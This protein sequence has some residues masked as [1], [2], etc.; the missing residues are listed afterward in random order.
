MRRLPIIFFLVPLLFAFSLSAD[1]RN[2]LLEKTQPKHIFIHNRIVAQVQGKPI[3]IIDLMKKM[4]MIFYQRYPQYASSV[5]ARYQFYCV[6][7]KTV[8]KELIEKEL[9][10]ADAAEIKV[11]ITNGDVRQE[12]ERLF[13][14]HIVANLDK[15]GLSYEEASQIVKE[16]LLLK[17]MMGMRVHGKAARSVTPK[18]VR[19]LYE[20]YAQEHRSPDSWSY[21]VISV[22]GKDPQLCSQTATALHQQLSNGILSLEELEK[23]TDNNLSGCSI[24]KEYIGTEKELS[25]AYRA[26]LAALSPGSFS[27]PLEQTSK[28]KEHL[29]RIFYLISFQPGGVPSFQELEPQLKNQLIEQRVEQEG[30]LYMQ[31]LKNRFKVEEEN[32]LILDEKF[33]PF[34]LS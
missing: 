14:P 2:F 22:K 11:E 3:S 31:K 16:D 24:S 29:F 23:S 34:S 25:A 10:L 13:G 27:A 1:S 21:R 8:L 18:Q 30:E 12:M 9:M 4:D 32:A 28:N 33:Q 26:T 7:W 17:R 6:S 15:A 19:D 5:E 20:T